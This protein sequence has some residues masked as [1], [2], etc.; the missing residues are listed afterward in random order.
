[1]GNCCGLNCVLAKLSF[2]SWA[3]A[4]LNMTVFR[5]K[6]LKEEVKLEETC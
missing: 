1:M 6:L 2:Q 5:N 3:S 4:P